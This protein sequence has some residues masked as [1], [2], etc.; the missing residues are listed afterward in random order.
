M[1]HAFE[2]RLELVRL[3]WH[4]RKRRK[5]L[6]QLQSDLKS[7]QGSDYRTLLC[8]IKVIEQ[9]C[10]Y[11][12]ITFTEKAHFTDLITKQMDNAHAVNENR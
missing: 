12:F 10:S 7:L 2:T 3:P 11:G 1:K 9:A 8:L 5:S 4:A 6:Q